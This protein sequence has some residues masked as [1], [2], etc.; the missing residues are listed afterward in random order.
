[1]FKTL[2]INDI[3]CKVASFR[4][5]GYVIG[6]THQAI[7]QWVGRGIILPP[8]I[9]DSNKMH[10]NFGR[11]KYP[12]NYYLVQEVM[13]VRAIIYRYNQ[14]RKNWYFEES[15]VKEIH[16]AMRYW[17]ELL[18]KGSPELI[19]YPLLLEFRNYDDLSSWI[20]KAGG[21][22]EIAHELYRMGDKKLGIKVKK[23]IEI[24]NK[25]LKIK[26]SK[27]NAKNSKEK[28]SKEET[29]G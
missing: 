22:D 24:A 27:K 12:R 3:K 11:K 20:R 2:V 7:K 25:N 8:S 23:E 13:A 19:D 6:R 10:Y 16:E 21:T 26:R 9:Q 29:S 17:R 1:M 5:F 28:S 4:D 14:D 15:Q 18:R